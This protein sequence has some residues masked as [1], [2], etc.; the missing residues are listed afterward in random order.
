MEEIRCLIQLLRHIFQRLDYNVYTKTYAISIT[1]KL[2]QIWKK[3]ISEKFTNLMK[4]S[5]KVNLVY[6][7]KKANICSPKKDVGLLFKSDWLWFIYFILTRLHS[8][9]SVSPCV[10]TSVALL[11]VSSGVVTRISSSFL[12]SAATFSPK[13]SYALLTH[14]KPWCLLQ[15]HTTPMSSHIVDHYL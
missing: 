12:S 3:I 4:N 8:F 10:H 2:F 1:L 11:L 14:A 15:Y 6:L 9:D 13:N 5:N 7:K